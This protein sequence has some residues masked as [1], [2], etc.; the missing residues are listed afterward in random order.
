MLIHWMSLFIDNFFILFIIKIMSVPYTYVLVENDGVQVKVPYNEFAS[1]FITYVDEPN[2]PNTLGQQGQFSVSNWNLDDAGESISSSAFVYS[3]NAWRKIPTYTKHWEDLEPTQNDNGINYLRLLPVHKSIELSEEEKQNVRQSIDVTTATNEKTGIVKGTNSY[4]PDYGT[5]TIEDDGTLK[6]YN[7]TIAHAGTVQLHDGDESGRTD[8]RPIVYTKDAIDDKINKTNSSLP[9]A[10][11]SVKGCIIVGDHMAINN[12]ILT[13]N[14]AQVAD[15]D[16]TIY[17][18]VRYAPVNFVDNI[19]SEGVISEN[20]HVLSVAQSRELVK[21]YVDNTPKTVVIPIASSGTLGGVRVDSLNSNLQITSEGRLS[22]KQATTQQEGV[23]K[24]ITSFN[25]I[26]NTTYEVPTA[27]TIKSYVD[28]KLIGGA[29]IATTTEPGSIIIGQGL[30]IDGNG[31]VS[32]DLPVASSIQRGVVYTTNS[33][34]QQTASSGFVPSSKGVYDFVISEIAKSSSSGQR[35]SAATSTSAGIIT[36]Q[37]A[38]QDSQTGGYYKVPTLQY[39][40]DYVDSITSS[41]TTPSSP[42]E[43]TSTSSSKFWVVIG[44]GEF[45]LKQL[46]DAAEAAKVTLVSAINGVTSS[47]IDTPIANGINILVFETSITKAKLKIIIE[48]A[49]TLS[50]T[51]VGESSEQCQNNFILMPGTDVFGSYLINGDQEQEQ[52]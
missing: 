8:I 46:K 21:Y 34:T 23:V 5:V 3:N 32:T 45:T 29:K 27:Y 4:S 41:G 26:T 42:A 11:N 17:G 39:M 25:G 43:P 51:T 12:G 35:A 19:G 48:N 20:D 44:T 7:A 9:T 6:V 22:A 38:T 49:V 52:E 13:V 50:G 40:K 10:T 24:F 47:E 37:P 1:N 31:V 28:S 15:A 14:L 30:K 36:V 33:I 18:L 16:N 2:S